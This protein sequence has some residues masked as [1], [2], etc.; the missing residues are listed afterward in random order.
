MPDML[1]KLYDLPDAAPALEACA[2]QGPQIRR[3]MTPDKA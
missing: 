3:A 1:V 2:A